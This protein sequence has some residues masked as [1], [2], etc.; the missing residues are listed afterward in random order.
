MPAFVPAR[1]RSD[2]K[3]HV[4]GEVD[5]NVIGT[6]S[7]L[8]RIDIYSRQELRRLRSRVDGCRQTVLLPVVI[9]A[10]SGPALLENAPWAFHA[11]VAFFCEGEL[12]EL[13][14]AFLRPTTATRG[15]NAWAI[16]ADGNAASALAAT[17]K[18]R[19]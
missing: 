5:K 1:Y 15:N 4:V 14:V 2:L 18:R 7:K 10:Q 13:I 12:L 3:A 9:A 8:R 11:D 19:R 17:N 6:R 16:T